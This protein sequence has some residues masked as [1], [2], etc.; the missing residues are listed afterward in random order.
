MAAT[1]RPNTSL[2][3][4]P[5]AP[6]ALRRLLSAADE[7]K[8]TRAILIALNGDLVTTEDFLRLARVLLPGRRLT[9]AS[10]AV[11]L[12]G[13]AKSMRL[14]LL[15]AGSNWLKAMSG[16]SG[17]HAPLLRHAIACAVA[18]EPLGRESGIVDPVQAFAIGLLHH[19]GDALTGPGPEN[20]TYDAI[21]AAG[22]GE[23]VLKTVAA[24]ASLAVALREYAMMVPDADEPVGPETSIL[25][26]ADWIATR[27]GYAAPAFAG[28]PR[29]IRFAELARPFVTGG[30]RLIATVEELAATLLEDDRVRAARENAAE[31]SPVVLPE[32]LSQT[33]T[34]DLGPLPVLFSRVSAATDEES[35][36]VAVTAGVVEELGA[37][38]VFCLRLEDE[39]LKRAVLSSRGNVPMALPELEFAL[40][41]LAP[42]LRAALVSGR[43][44]LHPIATSGLS[45]L[46]SRSERPA[47]YVPVV[48]GK[49]VLGLFGVE[50]DDPTSL[51]PDLLAAIT[52]HAGLALK[53]VDLKR[54]SD[55]AKI[56]EL[57]GLFN[58]RGI[59]EV[60]DR[61]LAAP[62][63]HER[64]LG[65]ALIDCDHLKKVNDNFGHLY[66]DEYLRRISE[67]ARLTLRATDVL[68][69]YGGDEFLA[70]LPGLRLDQ[71]ETLFERMRER[72]ELS[73][74]ESE[75]GLLLSISVG[76]VVRGHTDAS[77][78][79]LLKLAD[80]ALYQVKQEGRNAVRVLDAE[81]APD[82]TM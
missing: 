62:D 19:V 79:K 23:D 26:V 51:S 71:A 14:A 25:G 65:V 28:Q 6:P 30:G 47:F 20:G 37:A 15:A 63:V 39:R 5:E 3:R 82:L 73:G 36:A 53:A 78:D 9:A 38:R 45:A 34:R 16:G 54:Q 64:G 68:G 44:V 59:L 80:T 43:P 42:P 70:I 31:I 21:A 61:Q 69:R 22:L 60:L 2:E 18:A 75:D 41:D 33:S 35:L 74:L 12:L 67:V 81:H 8:S 24:P 66:G 48:A 4:L 11:P 57:T 72:V 50:L 49:E 13:E 1:T 77:R 46:H 10:E 56:D 17:Y 55:A 32:T 7:L 29:V 40:T 27:I 58:R 52:A 76:A